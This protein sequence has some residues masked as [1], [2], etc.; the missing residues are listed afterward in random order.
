MRE[1]IHKRQMDLTLT[2]TERDRIKRRLMA[3][4]ELLK[5]A[6]ALRDQLQSQL[7]KEQQDVVK[8]GSFSFAN[9]LKQLTGKWDAQMEKEIAEAAEAELKFNDAEKTA[10][11]LEAEVAAYR[12][13]M[14]DP[15][16]LWIDEEWAAFLK[17]KETWIRLNDRDASS[18]L[19]QIATDRISLHAFKREIDEAY[20]AGDRAVRA[21]DLALDKLGSAEGMSLWD[22]FLG[23]GLIVSAMKYSE[24]NSSEDLIHVAQRAL[25]HFETE[26]MD[27]QQVAAESLTIDQKDLLTFTDLFF[28]NIFSDWM[29]HSKITD[30]KKKVTGILQ[31]VRRTLHALAR[32]RDEVERQ[33]NQLDV[34]EREIIEA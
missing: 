20:D 9:K 22:T 34:K 24:I 21:L 23:G 18:T 4:E 19:E 28:D 5:D 25:R 30:T 27:V 8:L 32:K 7:T 33:L 17:E 29:I 6:I 13:R 1:D 12:E 2:R 16:F 3:A 11:D 14:D 10:Q 31:D 26:L 15:A